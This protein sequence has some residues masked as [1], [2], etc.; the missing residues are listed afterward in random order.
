MRAAIWQNTILA[1]AIYAL[2]IAVVDDVLLTRVALGR[3]MSLALAFAIVQLAAILL[4]VTALFARKQWNVMRLARSRRIV[5]LIQEVLALHAIG[6]DQ[7]PRLQELRRRSANDVRDTLFA[8]LASMRGQPRER[9]ALVAADLGFI[10][11]EGQEAIDWIRNLIRVSH[12]RRFEQIVTTVAGQSLLVRAIAAEELSTYAALIPESQLTRALQSS[13]PEVIVTALEML[14]AWRR[15]LH[16]R[17]FL[18][19]LRHEDARVRA[20]ALLA[21]PYAAADASPESL[22]PVIV[23]ALE[24]PTAEVRAAAAAVAGRMGITGAVNALTARLTDGE[25]HVAVAAAFAL[26]ALGDRGS[27][28]LQRAVLSPDRLAASVAFEALE[29]SALGLAELV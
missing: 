14:R 11:Q 10:E 17:N 13:N 12:G 23:A 28:L 5:P 7:R 24:H 8:M 6:I 1:A 25:R 21:L 15:A 22:A 27:A 9:V 26:A 2:A 20:S 3:A 29:K 4:M 19:L 18:P 16:V